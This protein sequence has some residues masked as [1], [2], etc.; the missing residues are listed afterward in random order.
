MDSITLYQGPVA[1]FQSNAAYVLDYF[2]SIHIELVIWQSDMLRG[3]KI[4]FIYYVHCSFSTFSTMYLVRAET[5]KKNHFVHGYILN[6]QD[7]A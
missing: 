2:S 3:F 4:S 1:I 6:N 5:F 7:S